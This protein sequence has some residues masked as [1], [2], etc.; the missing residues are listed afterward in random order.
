[1]APQPTHRGLYARARH[2]EGRRQNRGQAPLQTYFNRRVLAMLQKRGKIMVGWDEILGP[3]LPKEIII[4][5]WRGKKWLLDAVKQGHPA[6]LSEGYYLDLNYS[7]AA[8]YLPDPL[9]VGT[10]L[11]PAQQKL[12]L[13]GEVAMWSEFADSVIVDSR[14]WPRAAAVAERLWSPQATTQNVAD[15]YRRLNLVSVKLE[16]LGLRHR[17]A[18]AQAARPDGWL[19]RRG[20]AA[21]P[22]RSN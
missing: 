21:H 9:P 19:L 5:S 20:P 22:G 4:Q 18:P 10:P 7:A 2:G 17:S 15:M 13:G 14:I 3:D 11:T 12:V 8:H 16:A 6:L 1:M